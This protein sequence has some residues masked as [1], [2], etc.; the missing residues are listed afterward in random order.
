MPMIGYLGF[1]AVD[2]RPNL[3][4]AFLQGL[5]QTGFVVG[6]NVTIEHRSA[7]G[8]YER[9]PVLAGG[10]SL[11]IARSE[12]TK[13]SRLRRRTGLLRFARNDELPIPRR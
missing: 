7:D 1:T 8:D 9:L 5:E 2:E 6:H 4:T 11:V 3:L 12:A 13:Q 10:N